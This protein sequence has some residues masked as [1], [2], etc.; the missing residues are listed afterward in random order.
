MKKITFLIT[1]FIAINTFAQSLSG[2]YST[3]TLRID[4]STTYEF[5][6]EV[7]T[8]TATNEYLTSYIGPY[9]CIGQTPGGSNTVQITFGTNAGFSFNL[10]G[11]NLLVPTQNLA[12]VFSNE[13]RQSPQQYNASTYDQNTGQLV[14]EYSIFFTENTV[15]RPYRSTYTLL[16]LGTETTNETIFSYF[17]NPVKDVLNIHSSSAIIINECKIYNIL[18]Q[19]IISKSIKEN[20]K[21]IDV[22]NLAKG[23]YILKLFFNDKIEN[24]SFIKE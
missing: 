11:T 5:S 23:T 12:S 22:S 15:E 19:E 7:I 8:Q 3:S 18:G 24:V 14:I 2:N 20:L 13:V 6:N 17:P 16:S 9:Y 10:V 21:A 1:L 4:N